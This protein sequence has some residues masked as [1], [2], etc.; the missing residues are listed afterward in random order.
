MEA[1]GGDFHLPEYGCGIGPD[2]AP[3]EEAIVDEEIDDEE[4]VE[5]VEDDY[6]S[7]ED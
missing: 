3:D 5:V 4:E 1:L 7:D 2:A 6:F